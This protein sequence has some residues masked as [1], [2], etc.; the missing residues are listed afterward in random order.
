M[1]MHSKL[2]AKAKHPGDKKPFIEQVTGDDVRRSTGT[3]V[4]HDR[5]ID[6]ENN[7]YKEDVVDPKTGEV[8]HHCD[9]PLS[10]HT[11]HGD[12]KETR[13]PEDSQA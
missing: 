13:K 9:E 8:I 10:E 3:W 2:G 7:R 11:G 4:K 5:V 1:E 12:A 6:R